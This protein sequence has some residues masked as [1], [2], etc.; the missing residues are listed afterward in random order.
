M[1]IQLNAVE[2]TAMPS[3]K[4][5][6]ATAVNL[7]FEA[8]T[9]RLKRRSCHSVCRSETTGKAAKLCT[10]IG[11]VLCLQLCRP[12]FRNQAVLRPENTGRESDG[13]VMPVTLKLSETLH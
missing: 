5:S 2:A 6:T 3:A 4:L 9:L 7:G 12:M 1:S 11:S 13:A 8:N 10:G